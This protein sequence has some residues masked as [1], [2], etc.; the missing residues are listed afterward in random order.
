MNTRGE[1]FEAEGMKAKRFGIA[2]NITGLGF[3]G[4]SSLQVASNL[5]PN[6]EIA[7]NNSPADYALIALAALTAVTTANLHRRKRVSES[8]TLRAA[9]Y[10][11]NEKK[12]WGEE[13]EPE[14]WAVS[15]LKEANLDADEVIESGYGSIIKPKR[16]S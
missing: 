8:S 10:E 2:R 12:I 4:V 6:F 1:W 15:A 3:I 9:A 11:I 5:T 14:G 16:T 13:Y 7:P